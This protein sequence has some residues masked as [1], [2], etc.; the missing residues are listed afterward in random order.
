MIKKFNEFN[1]SISG[2]ELIGSMGPNYGPTN[3]PHKPNSK[4]TDIIYSDNF[5]KAVTYDEYQ[6]LYQQY[7]KKGGSPIHGFN[8]TNLESILLKLNES[9]EID[10][11][12]ILDCFIDI[13]DLG[14]RVEFDEDFD[15]SGT[16][17]LEI[18]LIGGY[19]QYENYDGYDFIIDMYNISTELMG[20]SLNSTLNST[21]RSYLKN[22]EKLKNKSLKEKI[23]LEKYTELTRNQFSRFENSFGLIVTDITFQFSEYGN[24]PSFPMYR[25]K[26]ER[27]KN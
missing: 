27:N 2:T 15:G 8:L 7:L 11:E 25:I 22:R 5:G 21:S 14:A 19:E 6:D 10:Q 1:E 23:N 16:P 17:C 4:Y 26:F 13:S 24:S 3:L 20:L 18:E 12:E 9:L